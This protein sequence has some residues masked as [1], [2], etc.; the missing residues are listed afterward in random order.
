[1]ISGTVPTPKGNI[2]V[3]WVKRSGVYNFVASVPSGV[4]AYAILNG[5]RFEINGELEVSV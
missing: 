2:N 3:S 1:M 5:K 4:K